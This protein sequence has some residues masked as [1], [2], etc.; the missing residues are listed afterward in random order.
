VLPEVAPLP[1]RRVIVIPKRTGKHKIIELKSLKNRVKVS[2]VKFL[3][4]QETDLPFATSIKT[5]FKKNEQLKHSGADQDVDTDEDNV[6]FGKDSLLAELRLAILSY[7]KDGKDALSQI[8]NLEPRS[9]FPH[10][11][12]DQPLQ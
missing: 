12:L 6:I 1:S 9:G 2:K 4:I 5:Q 10:D 7:Q 3:L 11:K 8:T